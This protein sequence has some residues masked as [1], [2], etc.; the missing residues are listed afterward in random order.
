[1]KT[2]VRPNRRRSDTDG[3]SATRAAYRDIAEEAYRL[4]VEDG[5][6]RTR[7]LVYWDLAEKHITGSARWPST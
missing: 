7:L 5:C 6:N 2:E 1:M 3:R 4:Y